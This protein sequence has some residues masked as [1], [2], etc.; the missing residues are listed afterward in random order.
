MVS[1][2]LLVSGSEG[3]AQVFDEEAVDAAGAAAGLAVDFGAQA[4]AVA[5]ARTAAEAARVLRVRDTGMP[6][7]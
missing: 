7:L 6:L 3:A 1:W 2:P 4:E 5:T